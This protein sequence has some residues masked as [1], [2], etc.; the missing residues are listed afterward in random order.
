MQETHRGIITHIHAAQ[1]FNGYQPVDISLNWL[2]LDHV[3]PL[4]TCHFK[5][6]YLGCQQVEVPT[7]LILENTLGLVAE[8]S[9]H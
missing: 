6:V 5:D 4:L 8:K 1:Q 3:V 9:A 2:P 7:A